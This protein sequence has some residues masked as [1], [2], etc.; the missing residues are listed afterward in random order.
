MQIQYSLLYWA[1][2]TSADTR[3]SIPVRHTRAEIIGF[4]KNRSVEIGLPCIDWWTTVRLRSAVQQAFAYRHYPR[5]YQLSTIIGSFEIL[6]LRRLSYQLL[7]LLLPLTLTDKSD[8]D[9]IMISCSWTS[10][11][12]D[13]DRF[14]RVLELI[15]YERLIIIII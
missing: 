3:S 9:F 6:R 13:V 2:V 11:P 7:L 15:V 5:R 4:K 10:S 12:G 14:I 1:A 8:T